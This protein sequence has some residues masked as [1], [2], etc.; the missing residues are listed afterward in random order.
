[1]RS[2][3]LIL[4]IVQVALAQD[5]NRLDATGKKHGLW[6]GSYADTNRPRYEGTFDHGKEVGIFTYFDNTKE[7]K[8]IATRTFN[9]LENTCYTIVYN[10]NGNKVSEGKLVNR[11]EEGAWKFYH[12]DSPQIMTYELY[13]KGKLNGIRK[14]F[15]KNGTIAEECGYKNGKR[16]GMY[17]KL[18]EEG[19]VLEESTYKNGEYDGLAIFRTANNTIAAK[20]N[21][22]KGKK[23]GIWEVLEKG[24]LVKINMSKVKV[25]KFEKIPITRE[26]DR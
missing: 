9:A 14:V 20:G 13:N 25:R 23:E 5:Y 3:L 15:Y 7:G 11:I 16:D 19:I 4:G 1:M 8:V 17:R 10:Q 26:E 21:F 24:K 6:K 22:V 2:L 12:E 18:T